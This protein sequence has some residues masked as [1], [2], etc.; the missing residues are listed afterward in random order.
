MGKKREKNAISA[1]KKEKNKQLYC[2]LFNLH[3]KS[4]V[5]MVLQEAAG[6]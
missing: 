6:E 5:V 2:V 4:K 1:S 3:V